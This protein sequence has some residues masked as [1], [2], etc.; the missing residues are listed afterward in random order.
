VGVTGFATATN[1][2]Y[3]YEVEIDEM[4]GAPK[5]VQVIDP[6]KVIAASLPD[7]PTSIPYQHDGY[8]GILLG[9]VLPRLMARFA[10]AGLIGPPGT[11]P[12]LPSFTRQLDALVRAL[13]DAE[14]LV[15]NYIPK[16]C[17]I[18]RHDVS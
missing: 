17:V 10:H 13:R 14:L 9:I 3:V 8:P 1:P 6:V 15:E 12:G 5:N 18:D 16:D 11:G 4:P 7:P 2:G